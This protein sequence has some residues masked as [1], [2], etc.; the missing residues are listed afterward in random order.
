MLKRTKGKEEEE[1]SDTGIN[2]EGE[3][4]RKA[5]LNDLQFDF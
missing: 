4:T 1:V 3:N 5:E 2:D